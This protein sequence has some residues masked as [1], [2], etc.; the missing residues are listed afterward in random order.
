VAEELLA[1]FPDTWI[2]DAAQG[3]V[4]CVFCMQGLEGGGAQSPNDYT[5]FAERV[6]ALGWDIWADT[7]RVVGHTG[8]LSFDSRSF[9]SG[10]PP[11]AVGFMPWGDVSAARKALP[12]FY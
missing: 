10:L 6:R 12:D 3:V 2:A 8:R 4:P 9:Y 11:V 1:F 7:T 5:A